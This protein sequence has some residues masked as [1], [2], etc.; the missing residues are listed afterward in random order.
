MENLFIKRKDFAV[1]NTNP[2]GVFLQQNMRIDQSIIQ[3]AVGCSEEAAV[4]PLKLESIEFM[5]FM[6][7]RNARK[8][9]LKLKRIKEQTA[10][11]REISGLNRQATEQQLMQKILGHSGYMPQKIQVD[12][13]ATVDD[14]FLKKL[15]LLSY[16]NYLVKDLEDFPMTEENLEE[17]E[18]NPNF[19]IRDDKFYK[20]EFGDK[21]IM[22]DKV[23]NTMHHK[24]DIRAFFGPEKSKKSDYLEAI[25]PIERTVR[26]SL[27]RI[28][29]EGEQVPLLAKRAEKRV[30]HLEKRN[31]MV[32][33]YKD[34]LLP[35]FKV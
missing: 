27:E 30:Q 20:H 32:N 25:K 9:H 6:S 1:D 29:P 3:Q 24:L 21:I 28:K 33:T 26:N 16:N 31:Q 2:E 22:M 12:K 7:E 34:R 8:E 18:Q 17:F 15:R 11:R 19:K 5:N 13:N 35:R 10:Y 4:D 14:T 23:E